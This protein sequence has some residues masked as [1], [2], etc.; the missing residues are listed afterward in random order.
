MEQAAAYG[1]W[2]QER[3][4]L[5][6][7]KDGSSAGPFSALPHAVIRAP[8]LSCPARLLYAVVQMYAW[9]EGDCRASH[10]TL[11][12]D[13]GCSVRMLRTYLD[14]LI[15]AGLLNEQGAGVRRQ[16]V[17]RLNPIGSTVPIEP[18]NENPASD[19]M[20]VNRK[21]PT[22]QSEISDTSNR[23][24][25]SDSKKKTTGK[26]KLE[27][28]LTP[29][30]LGDA[31]APQPATAE[32]ARPKAQRGTRCPESFELT[33]RHLT[34]AA[35]L[36]FTPAQARAETE[37]FLAHHRFKGTVGVDWYAGWQNWL[38]KALTFAGQLPRAGSAPRASAPAPAASTQPRRPA[39][40]V[41]TY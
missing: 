40:N 25:S 11:A 41:R 39:T 28:E 36:G 6:V 20:G 16:K 29:T 37:K 14:E 15:R 21:Y 27:E 24:H 7:V 18:V 2:A 3:P 26:K 5:V 38:R 19:S 8:G 32:P 17:Y 4:R 9:S 34:Y 31:G 10:A 23:K 12:A 35:T 1:P 13:L 33:E 30:G 22:V